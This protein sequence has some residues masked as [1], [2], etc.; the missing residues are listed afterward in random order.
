MPGQGSKSEWVSDQGK[1]DMMGG[2]GV[3]EGK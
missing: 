3:Q 1:R 2:G